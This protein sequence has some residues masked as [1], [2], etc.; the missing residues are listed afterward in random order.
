MLAR[1]MP[2]RLAAVAGLRSRRSA[3]A[4]A[5]RSTARTARSVTSLRVSPSPSRSRSM[6]ATSTGQGALWHGPAAGPP[7]EVLPK[8]TAPDERLEILVGRG[9]HAHVDLYGTIA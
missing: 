4:I 1:L 2:S 3:A 8:L 7:V 5:A 9:D 6:G